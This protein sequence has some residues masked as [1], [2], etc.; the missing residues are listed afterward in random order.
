M[1]VIHATWAYGEL[2][3]WAE[4]SVLPAQAP[5]RAGHPSRAPR[6]HPFAVPAAALAAALA[7][8]LPAAASLP[9][10][11]E[12]TL[13]LPSAA[14]GPLASPELLRPAAAEPAA[15]G[16]RPSLAGWRVPALAVA[17]GSAAAF[18]TALDG[19][20]PGGDLAPG[21]ETGYLAAV[22][23]FSA[24][25]AARGLVLPALA[26]DG[27]GGYAARWRPVLSGADARYARELA[28][29]LPPAAGAAHDAAPGPL[30]AG[31][32]DALTDA[33]VRALL[34]GPVLPP[35]RGR[36]PAR[37]DIAER[38]L[39]ALTGPVASVEL[40]SAADEADATAVAAAFAGWLA[41]AAAPASAVRT[42]FRLV[43]PPA[44][45]QEDGDLGGIAPGSAQA[46]AGLDAW[47]VEFSLQSVDDLSL[48]LPAADVWAGEGSGWL[49]GTRSPGSRHPE[50][51]L[52]AGLGT[53]ARL[54][55][56]LDGALRT[57]APD[58]VELDTPQA[59]AFLRDTA[60][61]LSGAGF[62]VL[63]PDWARKARLKLKLT[64]RS[65][66]A[67]TASVR[68]GQFGLQ[69]LVDFRYDLA[70]GDD[71]L[72]PEELAELARL[73]AP[74][75][76]VR[77]QWVELDDKHLKAA[78]KF[79][80]RDQSG[81]MTAAEVL[82][83]ALGADGG[84][85]DLPLAEVAADGWLGD[86]LS[87]QADERLAPMETPDGFRGTLRPYQQRGLAWLSFL[88]RLGI[89][90]VLADDMG[91]GKTVQLLSLLW[92]ERESAALVRDDPV[93]PT[94]LICPMSLTGNWQ[95]EAERFA[96]ELTVHVHHGA[97][98]LAGDELPAALGAADLVITTYQT[99][100]RDLAG[101]S[102]L[103]WAR[104]VCDEAQAIKNHL[105]QQAKAVRALPAASRIA[106]TGT[107]VE[108]QLSELWSIMEFANPGLLGSAK[109]FRDAYAVP[110][111]RHGSEEAAQRLRR[112]TQPFVLR[113]LKTDKTIISDLPDKQE[114]KVWCNLTA[115]QASLYE[116]TV[117]DMLAKIDGADSD[118]SRRGLVLATMTR[119]KQVCNHPAQ[120]LGDGS[121]LDGRSGK[122]DRL[123]GLCEEIAADG[124][125]ALCFTQYA[126]FGRM[127]QP[128]LSARV[129]C[130]VFFLHG[131]TSR[132][133]RDAMVARFQETD[134]PVLFLLS[135]KA[136]GTGLN[137]TAANHV[138]HVDR[139]WNPAVEDQ[140]TDRAFRIGQR[141][142]VQVRK[143]VCVGT[144]E[145]R[146]DAMIE[147]KKALAEQ[148]VGTGESWLAELST[149]A[150]RELLTLSPE[151]VSA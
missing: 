70:I 47:Q 57:A 132:K 115:E 5:P 101:L 131:G 35:R 4:D 29:A 62:G 129:G 119:L 144:L 78:L 71:V 64:A 133:Q 8:L 90:A 126:E 77:G 20:A 21:G 104:V 140:A 42:C 138:I 88:G 97:G 105:S 44:R 108:N 95:R 127:L 65:S 103:R 149:A 26:A 106:L 39:A 15:G 49:A 136:G 76:R 143:F 6:P 22:A 75:V 1:L 109:S 40:A 51:E 23:R 117:T 34:P 110:I 63:L 151:A 41:V 137:L 135:L 141:R 14:G 96:P 79:L 93:Y 55:P 9:L 146:I 89:G 74:L 86:L 112:V 48:M 24:D 100:T 25:L 124:D 32:L 111:E 60:P 58:R 99:V 92:K 130:Q 94:L 72:S 2:Y 59:L 61:L 98:R 114:M 16:H 84:T 73:K 18:L 85:A 67:S 38:M 139:W 116:A 11:D 54:F 37:I 142:D 12:L 118:I 134:E 10:D 66:S 36:R 81:T 80:E 107:P 33:A 150:L 27:G 113:R 120:L 31:M 7:P 87:C 102:Q 91:L 45:D 125:K 123:E 13:R 43:E 82:A 17:S 50:E 128:Y 147:Q 148:I 3:A 56:A 28:V 121:R 68:Q 30:L 52:L 69:D 145:E 46:A 53:A 83:V 122:L 19:L